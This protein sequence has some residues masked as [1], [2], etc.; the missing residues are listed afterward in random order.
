MSLI[1]RL[2]MGKTFE[3]ISAML[4]KP[5]SNGSYSSNSPLENQE[6]SCF[7]LCRKQ[8]WLLLIKSDQCFDFI[9]AFLQA[10]D[11]NQKQKDS[12]SGVS[13]LHFQETVCC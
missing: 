5:D 13:L 7:E 8:I 4:K 1:L 11:R 12:F 2:E 10:F 3:A 6:L 9:P